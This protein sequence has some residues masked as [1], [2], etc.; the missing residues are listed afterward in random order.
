MLP[1]LFDRPFPVSLFY[2]DPVRRTR[3]RSAKFVLIWF[4]W[5]LFAHRVRCRATAFAVHIVAPANGD[6]RRSDSDSDGGGGGD[7]GDELQFLL[8]NFSI[9]VIVM[10]HFNVAAI[11][12]YV[13]KVIE[14]T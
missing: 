8:S 4:V 12:M 5:I 14:I 7:G 10:C 11:E 9:S 6:S 3:P 13:W 1:F 2:H